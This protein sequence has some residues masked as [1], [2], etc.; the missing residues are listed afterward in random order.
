M[1]CMFTYSSLLFMFSRYSILLLPFTTFLLFS[2]FLSYPPL[3]FMFS[4]SYF[5][6]SFL[7]TLSPIFSVLF[8]TFYVQLFSYSPRV[9]R[10]LPVLLS[11]SLILLYRSCLPI[12]L[13]YYTVHVLL[14]SFSTSIFLFYSPLPFHVFF[15]SPVLLFSFSPFSSSLLFSFSVYVLSP[16]LLFSFSPVSCSKLL[17][18]SYFPSLP[19][20]FSPLSLMLTLFFSS[21]L[22]LSYSLIILFS[23]TPMSPIFLFSY[24]PTKFC[25]V[26]APEK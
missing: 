2:C 26:L 23:Y 22:L 4:F 25:Y 11:P 5:L 17:H 7:C 14:F 20:S 21:I 19:L 1:L 16:V 9:I 3:S 18:F 13:Y 15:Y 8:C 12:L 24:T 6:P 10:V